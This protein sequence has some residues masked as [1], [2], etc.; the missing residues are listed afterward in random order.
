MSTH[1]THRL[2]FLIV[3]LV[4]PAE[5]GAHPESDAGQASMTNSNSKM[6]YLSAKKS[7]GDGEQIAALVCSSSPSPRVTVKKLIVMLRVPI[8]KT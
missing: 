3:I 8:P 6:F 1:N 4:S 5:S 2:E 7:C